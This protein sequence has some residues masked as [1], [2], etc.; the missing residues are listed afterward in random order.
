MVFFLRSFKTLQD[1][2]NMVPSQ[3]DHYT[4]KCYRDECDG[5]ITVTKELG[6]HLFIEIMY[7]HS[8]NI[9]ENIQFVSRHR[10][11]H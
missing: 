11:G 8:I 4:R 7:L 3:L 1:T 6:Q 10:C 5:T 9:L 2:I